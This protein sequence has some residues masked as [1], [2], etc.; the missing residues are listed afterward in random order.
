MS[1][2]DAVARAILVELEQH[3][4]S[5]DRTPHLIS[6]S[7]EVELQPGSVP[8]VTCRAREIGAEGGPVSAGRGGI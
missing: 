3:R 5:I 7:F 8:A 6:V 2:T 4:A 1:R